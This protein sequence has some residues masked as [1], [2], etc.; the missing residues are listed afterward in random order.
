MVYTAEPISLPRP[1]DTTHACT[2]TPQLYPQ[3]AHHRQDSSSMPS[4]SHCTFERGFMEGPPDD[5]AL[6]APLYDGQHHLH[7]SATPPY[8]M[9]PQNAGRDG[10]YSPVMGDNSYPQ[11]PYPGASSSMVPQSATAA[12]A[13]RPIDPAPATAGGR[14]PPVLRPMPVGGVMSQLGMKSPY[15]QRPL[16]P[17][18]S[19][20]P[21]SDPPTHVVGSQGR[22]GI[23]PSTPGPPAAL[24]AG[25]TQA[26]NQI[27]LKMLTRG[28]LA[29]TVPTLT[30]IRST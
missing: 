19:M 4:I 7:Q 26:N 14:A 21:D 18:A 30:G 24:V 10:T 27:F 22:R 16:M 15:S 23:L 5:P 25:T 3:T 29:L 13:P 1:F 6:S 17:R 9:P 8:T 28:S 20:M 11:Q 12:S 2:E